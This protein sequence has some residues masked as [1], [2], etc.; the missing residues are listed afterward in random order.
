MAPSI[1]RIRVPIRL[2][3]LTMVIS[4]I[5][6]PSFSSVTL[7]TITHAMTLHYRP[8]SMAVLPSLSDLTLFP[9]IFMLLHVCCNSW[10]INSKGEHSNDF[11]LA[12]TWNLRRRGSN[13]NIS[14]F[15]RSYTT[16][17]RWQSRVLRGSSSSVILEANCSK[18]LL[19]RYRE[20][21]T[22]RN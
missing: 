11:V 18:S 22:V 19:C 5:F 20:Q 3:L 21:F 16:R 17:D 1:D 4:C 12:N 13:W 10:E 15:C 6:Y 8:T 7:D 14:A 2:P 9:L